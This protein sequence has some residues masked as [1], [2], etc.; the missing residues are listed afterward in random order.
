MTD[1][2]PLAGFIICCYPCG[3]VVNGQPINVTIPFG[4]EN[5]KVH[6]WPF[7]IWGS[8]INISRRFI[9]MIPW[10]TMNVVLSRSSSLIAKKRGRFQV[11]WLTWSS[12]HPYDFSFLVLY[13]SVK[14]GTQGFCFFDGSFR[15]QRVSVFFGL[16]FVRNVWS[17]VPHLRQYALVL[18]G[19]KSRS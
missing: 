10:L 5:I 15:S 3:K 17:N 18:R 13:G 16:F 2:R 7:H 19:S 6:L 14:M 11:I 12:L 9:I 1:T 4:N 8:L